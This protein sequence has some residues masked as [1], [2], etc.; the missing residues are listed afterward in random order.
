MPRMHLFVSGRVQG[1]GFRFFSSR[2]A[3]SLGLTGFVRN[4]QD[5]RVEIVAEGSGEKLERFLERIKEGTISASV[6][7]VEVKREEERGEFGSF[8]IRF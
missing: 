5:G 4:L 3:N 6:E 7:S 2:T 8:E 1:V